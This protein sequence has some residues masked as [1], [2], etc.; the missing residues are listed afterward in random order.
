MSATRSPPPPCKS[1]RDQALRF[2]YSSLN[3]LSCCQHPSQDTFASCPVHN[4]A[5]M[6]E[7]LGAVAS[8]LAVAKV[9][10]KVGGT[11]W[12]LKKLW[13]EVHEVPAAI[14]DLMRQIEMMEPILSAHETSLSIQDTALPARFSACNGAPTTQSAAHCREALDDLQRLVEDLDFAVD[15]EKRRTRTFARMKVVL[16]KHTIKGFQDRLERATRLLQ[17]AQVS[18]LTWVTV[19]ALMPVS[20]PVLIDVQSKRRNHGGH[21]DR[22]I[23]RGNGHTRTATTN[24]ATAE[25]QQS[26]RRAR[27]S[28]ISSFH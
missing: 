27:K 4:K 23:D 8:G 6:A 16:K 24:D 1:I 11:V 14:R 3:L 20:P 22:H 18:Y 10:L 26:P 12:K 28:A 9:G 17:L 25:Q 19:L 15:S 21:D 5:N 13:Q 7:I 2:S